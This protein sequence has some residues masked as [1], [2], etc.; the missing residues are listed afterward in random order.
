M[1]KAGKDL[2]NLISQ[3]EY[4]RIKWDQ[5]TEDEIKENLKVYPHLLEDLVINGRWM[6]MPPKLFKFSLRQNSL[7]D[8]KL[9]HFASRKNKFSN[10]PEA[11][12]TH[13]LL[14]LKGNGGQSVYHILTKNRETRLIDENLLTKKV[15]LDKDDANT[16]PLHYV[17]LDNPEI[18]FKRNLSIDDLFVQNGLGETPL[19]NW[20]CS[21]KWFMIPNKFLTKE[22]LGQTQDGPIA[23]LDILVQQHK[24]IASRTIKPIIKH[25]L[26]VIFSKIDNKDLK[27]LEGDREPLI[28]N[29][30]KRE[31][32]K[33]SVLN[34][35]NQ[36]TNLIDF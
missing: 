16:T 2:L 21:S 7:G 10:I 23:I 12:I 33:R 28:S 26:K 29:I 32:V 34:N 18:V 36:N 14:S 8:D 25:S 20:A 13:K 27:K 22:T 4:H 6:D 35:I 19:Y 1:H 31:L 5:V 15:L 11:L 24:H 9:I 30:A 3:K 17:V